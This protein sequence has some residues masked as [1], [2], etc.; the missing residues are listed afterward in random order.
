VSDHWRQALI[1]RGVPSAKIAVVMN[2]ADEGV[3][4]GDARPDGPVDGFR[5]LY[6]GTIT[7]RYGLDLALRAVAIARDEVPGLCLTIVGKGDDVPALMTLRSSLGL[8]RMVDIRDEF[9]PIEALPD[10]I[11]SADVGIVPYRD[12]VFTDGLLPTKLM[13][14]AEMRLPSIAART[15]AI[16]HYFAG[17]F[18][19]FFEPGDVEGLARRIVELAHAPARREALARGA[20]R[21][22]RRYNW[23]DVSDAYVDLV[24]RLDRLPLPA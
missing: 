17:S 20:D 24:A 10:L 4:R 14:Y 22:T 16:D 1:D 5:L 6:H 2:V 8:E 7:R 15:T 12:D 13:E 3:F 23:A 21:F 9:L 19:A 18:V 11:A